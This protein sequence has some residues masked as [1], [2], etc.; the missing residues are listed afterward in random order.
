MSMINNNDT[1][2]AISSGLVR[3]GIGVIRVS[4]PHSRE[5][6]QRIFFTRHDIPV[7]LSEPM[8]IYYGFVKNVSRET[9][10]EV[11]VLNM[12]G[13]H[14]FTG[15]DT[16]EIDCHGG[17]LMMRRVLEAVLAAGARSAEPGE[18]TKRAFLNGRMD[19][20]QAE[21]V[22][23]VINA[24]NDMALRSSISQL[25][26][27]L[28]V[29]ISAIREKILHEAAYIESALDD[30]EHYSLDG[31]NERIMSMASDTAAELSELISGYDTGRIIRNGIETV[32]LGLPNAGK[33][34]LL[35]AMLGE[36]RAIV[37]QIPGTTRD[38]VTES[39]SIGNITLRLSDTAG[40]R[41]SDD[42]VESIGIS[43][44]MDNAD[45]ADM[46]LCVIDASVPAD[47]ETVRL[48]EFAESKCCRKIYILNKIDT[49]E[50][51]KPED[52]GRYINGDNADIVR[53]SAAGKVNIRLLFEKIEAA[54][55]DGYDSVNDNVIVSSARHFE[56]LNQ[57]LNSMKNLMESIA[58]GMPEDLYT[59]DIMDAY[60]ALGEIT[61]EETDE[62]LVN[63]IFSKFCMGK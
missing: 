47:D 61:G 51:V 41:D 57:A 62:D 55:S 34:S 12:P 56:L 5:V 36:E 59:V 9:S 21:A 18:F 17:M 30:P 11:L 52:I 31:C 40:I 8:H 46:I 27:E 26:G 7:Q 10:D 4:G 33:S 58:S 23:D 13:P 43:R 50:V 60:R 63:E 2:A 6:V 53:I 45:K 38:T 39:V 29:R 28:S 49:Q 14:S 44:A 25:R 19:L 54:F 48:I 22:I 32:I 1:I 16:V 24:E 37:T 35:N 42:P 20:S 15:E 3:S